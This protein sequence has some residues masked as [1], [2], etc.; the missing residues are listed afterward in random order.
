MC[1]SRSV[2]PPGGRRVG[3]ERRRALGRASFT[4]AKQA[5]K[6]RARTVLPHG[7]RPGPLACGGDPARRAPCQDGV[8]RLLAGRAGRLAAPLEPTT[9]RTG[10]GCRPTRST[11]TRGSRT[12]IVASQRRLEVEPRARRGRRASGQRQLGVPPAG[13]GAPH[14]RVAR[15]LRLAWSAAT[16]SPRAG[17]PKGAPGRNALDVHVLRLRRRL[18]PLG[19]A[20]RTVR[21]RGYLLE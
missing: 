11:C 4:F 6:H 7:R 14:A 18:A 16:R 8:P 21:V 17:W 13:R 5:T 12:S 1:P 3:A 15:R 9:S 10:S 19:L 20:I 2:R